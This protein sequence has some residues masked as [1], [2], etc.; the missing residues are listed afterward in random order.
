MICGRGA[1][2]LS[3][4]PGIGADRKW[5]VHGQNDAIGLALAGGSSRAIKIK[6]VGL[7]EFRFQ[8]DL[9][10]WIHVSTQPDRY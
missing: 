1:N 3:I 2:R 5:S 8:P 9:F 6:E 4:C 10:Q 7:M